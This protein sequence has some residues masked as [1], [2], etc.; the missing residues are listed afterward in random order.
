MRLLLDSHILLAITS[1]EVSKLG[2]GIVALLDA[3][4][5]QK[6]VSAASLWEL[7]IKYRL[8]KLRLDVPLDNFAD[9]FTALEYGLLN[10]DHR[11]AVEPLEIAPPTRDPFDRLLLAQCQIEGMRL[12]TRDRALLAHP[13]AWRQP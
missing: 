7:A 2:G 9:Y 8:S 1:R 12:V 6:F 4:E 5:H 10:V 13:L 3:T 11:H